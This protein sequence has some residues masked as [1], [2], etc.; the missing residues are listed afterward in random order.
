[1]D[2]AKKVGFVPSVN[3]YYATFSSRKITHLLLY[4][5]KWKS[6]MR[7]HGPMRARQMCAQIGDLLVHV[8]HGFRARMPRVRCAEKRARMKTC[9]LNEG[10]RSRGN[11]SFQNVH[12]GAVRRRAR[13]F[14]CATRIA[15]LGQ[16]CTVH[17]RA[18]RTSCKRM[19]THENT[20]SLARARKSRWA[21]FRF[22]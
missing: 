19:Y 3:N 15:K 4:A 17:L 8:V 16:T 9:T 7:V 1:M 14:P 22:L 11:P 20:K 10:L 13:G 5:N 2:S 18:I 12:G 6:Q 21:A